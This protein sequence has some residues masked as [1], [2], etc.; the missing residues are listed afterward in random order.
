MLLRQN[1][2]YK[3]QRN[4]YTLEE[5]IILELKFGTKRKNRK[6]RPISRTSG[7]ESNQSMMV[8][9]VGMYFEFSMECHMKLRTH[10]KGSLRNKTKK[11]NWLF[12]PDLKAVVH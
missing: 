1:I 10:Y 7:S 5:I 2:I 6:I 11:S 9:I 3:S 8:R 4:I 12:L